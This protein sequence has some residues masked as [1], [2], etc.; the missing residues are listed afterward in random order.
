[1]ALNRYRDVL[2]APGIKRLFVTSLIARAPQGMSSLSILLLVSRGHGYAKAG[3]VVGL[4]VAGTGAAAPVLG[5]LVDRT[6]ARVVLR[7]TAVA[8]GLMMTVLAAWSL[9]S[10]P[11]QRLVFTR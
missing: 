10:I 6:G 8:Y 5:R 2:A 9:P 1:M 11:L 3:L 4:Y 7:F